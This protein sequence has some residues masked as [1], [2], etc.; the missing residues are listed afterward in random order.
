MYVFE[1]LVTFRSTT[2][3]TRRRGLQ[4]VKKQGEF[5]HLKEVM[6]N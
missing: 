6:I 2:R 5:K 3:Q 1:L 4:N